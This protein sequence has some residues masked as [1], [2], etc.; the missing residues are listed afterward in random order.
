MN[1]LVTFRRFIKAMAGENI[2]AA[3]VLRAGGYAWETGV[4]ASV[5]GKTGSFGFIIIMIP[6]NSILIGFHG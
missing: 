5:R 3:I 1:F 4:S 2:M 6:C